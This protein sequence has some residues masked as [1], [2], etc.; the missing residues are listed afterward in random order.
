[1]FTLNK[2]NSDFY[3]YQP[4]K[5][6]APISTTNNYLGPKVGDDFQIRLKK[7]THT[8]LIQNYSPTVKFPK[9]PKKQTPTV[10][11]EQESKK[12][13]SEILKMKKEQAEKQKMLKFTIKSIDKAALKEYDQK[14]AIY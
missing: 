1:M 11:L 7:K 9:L 3:T 10:N 6:T 2:H 5:L 12:T 13:S 4:I 14:S 8:V